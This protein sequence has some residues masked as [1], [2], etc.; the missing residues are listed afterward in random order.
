MAGVRTAV[1]TEVIRVVKVPL[2]S[3]G[4]VESQPL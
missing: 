1:E 4:G 2:W 3:F